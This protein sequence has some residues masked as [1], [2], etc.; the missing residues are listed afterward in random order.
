M[1]FL[2]TAH[3]LIAG[4]LVAWSAL[5]S[6]DALFRRPGSLGLALPGTLD[7]DGVIWNRGI[8]LPTSSVPTKLPANVKGIELVDVASYGR[9]KSPDRVVAQ[10]Y[11]SVSSG[12]D[13][14]W[15]PFPACHVL[16]QPHQS[17]SLAIPLY[18][19]EAPLQWFLGLSGLSHR[20]CVVTSP[21]KRQAF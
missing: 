10:L 11:T 14:P 5:V 3:A 20:A 9:E 6:I 1:R 21:L 4:S 15:P 19:A 8:R 7:L 16:A 17:Q 18:S 12:A 2:P 13:V